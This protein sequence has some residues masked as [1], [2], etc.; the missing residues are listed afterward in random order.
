MTQWLDKQKRESV[1]EL[2]ETFPRTCYLSDNSIRQIRDKNQSIFW[3]IQPVVSRSVAKTKWETGKVSRMEKSVS[4]SWRQGVPC[5]A[6]YS[7]T[8]QGSELHWPTH[9]LPMCHRAQAPSLG[10]GTYWSEVG[11]PL[12]MAEE[13]QKPQWFQKLKFL[14]YTM[15][16]SSAF[17]QLVW[18]A[19]ESVWRRPEGSVT[20]EWLGALFS[21]WFS[22]LGKFI[23]IQGS[24]LVTHFKSF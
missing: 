3:E 17:G 19:E 15:V 1:R 4:W 14:F 22:I 20:I 23:S 16:W 13:L 11:C 12:R 7:W 6:G 8:A 21:L 10:Y 24:S 5:G 9:Y 2:W 18:W